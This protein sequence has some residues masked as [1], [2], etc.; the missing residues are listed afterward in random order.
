[1][2]ASTA[3]TVPSAN[4]NRRPIVLSLTPFSGSW[5]NSN[6]SNQVMAAHRVAPLRDRDGCHSI[7]PGCRIGLVAAQRPAQRQ[8]PNAAGGR[9]L[10]ARIEGIVASRGESVQVALRR[11]GK[12]QRGL[13]L[14][15][16]LTSS[17]ARFSEPA[18]SFLRD[19]LHGGL[20]RRRAPMLEKSVG[21]ESHV[22]CQRLRQI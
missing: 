14:A 10:H 21:I 20:E 7:L 17:L 13:K 15:W 2:A 5:I 16:H 3:N 9:L 6:P 19:R 18:P 8:A 4:L 22:R 1:M 12:Q 11:R